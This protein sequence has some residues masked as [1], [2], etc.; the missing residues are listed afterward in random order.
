MPL[1]Y[2]RALSLVVLWGVLFVIVLTMISGARELMTPG[3]WK[4]QGWTY[5]LAESS[6]PR[7]AAQDSRT[8]RREALE[9]LRLALWQFAA[10]HQ[11]KFPTAENTEI[12]AKLWEIPGWPGLKFLYVPERQ[13]E[14]SGAARLLVFEPALEGD[15]CQV[16]LTNGLLGTMRTA[17]I[18]ADLKNG[19]ES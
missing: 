6:P 7:P 4:K 3:A 9:Q 14:A 5:Q 10:T 8:T 18:T 2:R 12:D 17:E 13:L 15:E 1:G 16:I 19:R 11:G